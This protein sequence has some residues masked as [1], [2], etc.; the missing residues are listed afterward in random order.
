MAANIFLSRLSSSSLFYLKKEI[1]S[2]LQTETTDN[3]CGGN[4]GCAG[5]REDAQEDLNWKIIPEMMP[6]SKRFE[7]LANNRF[8]LELNGI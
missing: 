6:S 4:L 5:R 1:I 7:S 8:R 3:R 2:A